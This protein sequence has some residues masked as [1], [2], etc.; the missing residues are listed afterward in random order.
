[1]S[2]LGDSAA[3]HTTIVRCKFRKFRE[4]AQ[5]KKDVNEILAQSDETREMFESVR[6][7]I[8]VDNA[9]DS[10]K[11]MHSL[12]VLLRE[13]QSVAEGQ[14]LFVKPDAE[15]MLARVRNFLIVDED[16]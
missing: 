9:L 4:E 15:E 12:E 13:L 10:V 11:A 6:N 2:I 5:C 3:R 8:H 7:V 1:M 14:S 16:E